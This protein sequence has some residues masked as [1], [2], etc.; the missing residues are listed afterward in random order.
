MKDSVNP[1]QEMVESPRAFETAR[2]ID[3]QPTVWRKTFAS[4]T[5]MGAAIRSFL[6]SGAAADRTIVLTGAGSSEY[7]GRAIAG[8]LQRKLN[9]EVTTVPTTHFVTHCET[10]FLPHREYTLLSFARSGNSPESMATFQRVAEQFP[11][12]R[13]AV[14]TCNKDGTLAR[15]AGR[16]G[17]SL[18]VLLPEETNDRSLAMTS[19]FTSLALAGLS[20]GFADSFPSF[21]PVLDKAVAGA[22]RVMAEYGGCLFDFARLPFTRACYLGSNTLFGCMQEAR[23]KMQEM[24]AG[25]VVATFDSFLG[26]SHGPQVFVNGECVVVASLSSVPA[27]QRYELDLL[28][29]LKAKKQGIGTLIL[30]TKADSE[31]REVSDAVI[32]LFPSGEPLEDDYRVLTDIVAGQI[33]ATFKSVHLGLSPDNP[34]PEGVINRV[35]EGVRLYPFP[36]PP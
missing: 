9:V 30:C 19:S 6:F 32:E 23:L 5:A 14:I 25:R 11:R 18:C 15:I 8:A 20:L 34:S 16:S 2:E 33:L 21:E 26:L 28:K 27:V 36:S 22:A 13:Q 35:V 1:F 24:T 4:V 10:V 12:V 3:H 31:I 17:S 7:V 29:E